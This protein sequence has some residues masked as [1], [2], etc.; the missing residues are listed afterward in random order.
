MNKKI[1]GLVVILAGVLV[2][3]GAGCANKS[4]TKTPKEINTNQ[5]ANNNPADANPAIANLLSAD[6]SD[7]CN[8]VA[9][10]EAPNAL[11]KE[12]KLIFN[13]AGNE[14]KFLANIPKDSQTGDTFIYILKNKPTTEK[15]ENAFKKYGYKIEISGSVMVVA[16]N[17]LNFSN[18]FGCH[19][20]YYRIYSGSLNHFGF[21]RS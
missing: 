3:L 20:F 8:S 15:L 19:L 18:N 12:L 16:K 4:I 2:F 10:V 14:T 5:T 1:F 11:A 17:N 9:G 21:L 7:F 6:S 13:E